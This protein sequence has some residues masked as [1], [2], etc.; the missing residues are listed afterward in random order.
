MVTNGRNIIMVISSVYT[1]DQA[2]DDLVV[3]I[4]KRICKCEEK[5]AFKS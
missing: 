4:K 1:D 5:I 2:N 3:D